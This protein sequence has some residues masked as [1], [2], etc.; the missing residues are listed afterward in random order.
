MKSIGAWDTIQSI[1]CQP[2]KQMQVSKLK[3]INL[4]GVI[5]EYFNGIYNLGVGWNIRCPNHIQST[6]FYR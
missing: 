3:L 5:L 1:R 6:K 4:F 2:V